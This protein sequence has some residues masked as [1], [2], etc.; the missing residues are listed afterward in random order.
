MGEWTGRGGVL[1]T[2]WLGTGRVH[3]LP[4]SSR[5]L[6]HEGVKESGFL[7]RVQRVLCFIY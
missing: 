7:L 5:F 6:Y 4:F 1:A 3:V 2:L